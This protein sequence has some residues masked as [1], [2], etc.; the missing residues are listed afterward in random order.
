[1]ANK[2]EGIF[3]LV[4]AP[5]AGT[6]HTQQPGFSYP[7]SRDMMACGLTNTNEEI[8]LEACGEEGPPSSTFL[9]SR[10]L[11]ATSPQTPDGTG[12]LHNFFTASSIF[13]HGSI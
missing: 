9:S 3:S 1:M 8:S 6:R 2:N 7:G 5:D 11:T 13:L 4:A 10:G 12:M